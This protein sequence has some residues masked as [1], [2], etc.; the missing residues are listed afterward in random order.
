M[1]IDPFESNPLNRNEHFR[2]PSRQRAN[3]SRPITQELSLTSASRERR[4]H[5]V[6]SLT[7]RRPIYSTLPTPLLKSKTHLEC[8]TLIWLKPF[9]TSLVVHEAHAM[10]FLEFLCTSLLFPKDTGQSLY[11]CCL[12]VTCVL[13]VFW[14]KNINNF[15]LHFLTIF[16]FFCKFLNFYVWFLTIIQLLS[17]N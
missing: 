11:D 17:N 10:E 6:P 2:L 9:K 13:R 3:P 4:T 8:K 12:L 5:G 15:F 14:I 1:K 16:S 7:S